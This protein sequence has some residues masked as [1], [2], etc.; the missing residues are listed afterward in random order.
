[1]I[2]QS[3]TASST[4]TGNPSSNG[5]R[6]KRRS[7]P[8]SLDDTKRQ[9]ICAMVSSGCGLQDAARYVNCSV[10]TIRREAE[11]NPDFDDELRRSDV[12]A[13][14]NPLRAMQQ[15]IGTHWRAAAWFL[16]R[17]FPER[18]GKRD[19]SVFGPRE[20][21]QLLD[22]ML[23]IVNSEVDPLQA[24]RV[25]KRVKA[26]FEYYLRCASDRDRNSRSLRD[27]MAYFEQKNHYGDPLVR[28][29]FAP[30]EPPWRTKSAPAAP[31]EKPRRPQPRSADAE[32]TS[33]DEEAVDLSDVFNDMISVLRSHTGQS[34]AA[35]PGDR[36][37][38]CPPSAQ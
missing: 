34:S 19:R 37:N 20:A 32:H 3:E 9:I 1:M 16:E 28:F 17:A 22:E 11:R 10:R 8:R 26:T 5:K 14:L 38:F 30:A 12:H 13:K 35:E 23:R 33:S 18:F 31:R 27:A 6:S 15:A 7:R 21:R 36:T 2:P 4:E 24:D 29:G 25:E